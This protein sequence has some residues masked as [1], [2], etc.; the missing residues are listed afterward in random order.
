MEFHDNEHD[1][2]SCLDVW[3]GFYNIVYPNLLGEYF[4]F[5]LLKD[6]ETSNK[7][8]RWYIKYKKETDRRE[9]YPFFKLAGD[10]IFNFNSLKKERYVQLLGDDKEAIALLEECCNMHHTFENMA[11]LPITGSLNNQKQGGRYG[12]DRPDKHIKGLQELFDKKSMDILNYCRNEESKEAI[13]N[14]FGI[15]NNNINTYFNIIY[16]LDDK[17]IK[18][19]TEFANKYHNID[20]KDVAISYMNMAK[21][22]WIDRKKSIENATTQNLEEK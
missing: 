15:F 14:Y 19:L 17:W 7:C 1:P 2:D 18:R 12:W 6:D 20:S 13:I 5:S 9:K 4:D 22:F 8:K 16:L 3:K 21:D 11:L 10:C